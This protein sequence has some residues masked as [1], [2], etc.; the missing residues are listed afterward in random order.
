[1]DRKISLLKIIFSATIILKL[2][3]NIDN[4]QSL[5]NVKGDDTR[6]QVISERLNNSGQTIT[7]SNNS[8]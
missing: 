5:D 1:M 4:N 2:K 3:I 6:A 8:N 7:A